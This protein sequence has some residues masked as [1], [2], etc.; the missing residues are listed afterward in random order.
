[1][2]SLNSTGVRSIAHNLPPASYA[3][4]GRR[5]YLDV[6]WKSLHGMP[7]C[8]RRVALY[9]MGG[10]GKSQILQKYANDHVNPAAKPQQYAIVIYI[11]AHSAHSVFSAV[12]SFM[13]LHATNEALLNSLSEND[14]NVFHSWLLQRQNWLLILDNVQDYNHILDAIPHGSSGHILCSTRHK[15]IAQQF[16]NGY[17]SQ[18]LEVREMGATDSTDLVLSLVGSSR[19]AED[20]DPVLATRVASFA[21]GIPLVIEQVV[22]N[23]LLG[24]RTLLST[25]QAV[26]G[27]AELLRQKNIS[28]LHPENLALGGVVMQAFETLQHVSDKAEA[29]FS[30]LAYMEPSSIPLSML[31]EGSKQL[32]DYLE[33][34]HTYDRGSIEETSEGRR[35]R[36]DK[37][38]T[39][40][41]R[42]SLWEEVGPFR[43]RTW[44]QAARSRS[45]RKA[46]AQAAL[47][48]DDI[49]LTKSLRRECGPAS[50]LGRLFEN[51]IT[52]DD[53]IAV[54]CDAAIV[55]KTGSGTLWIHDLVSEVAKA[56][57]ADRSVTSSQMTALT[58]ATTVYLA[59]PVP[60][61]NALSKK[62]TACEQYLPHAIACHQNLK[63][64]GIL[65]DCSIGPELSHII[66]SILNDCTPRE[67]DKDGRRLSTEVRNERAARIIKYYTDAYGGYLAGWE[68]LKNNYG[69]DD[70][71][72]YLSAYADREREDN[73]MYCHYR[74]YGG[75]ERFGRSAPWRAIQ[76]AVKLSYQIKQ[77]LHQKPKQDPVILEKVLSLSRHAVGFHKQA[78]GTNDYDTV[79]YKDILCRQLGEL[80][81][82]W[83]D[84]YDFC[85]ESIQDMVGWPIKR[86]VKVD[87]LRL[88][89]G[90]CIG[91]GL[92]LDRF[93]SGA[94]FVGLA[95]R[96]CVEISKIHRN[97]GDSI[98]TQRCAE[99]AVTWCQLWLQW[100]QYTRGAE[101]Y[102]CGQVMMLLGEA[103]ELAGGNGQALKWY[104][105]A[106]DCRTNV[107][108]L[109]SSEFRCHDQGV[110]DAI[111]LFTDAVSR[112]DGTWET[113]DVDDELKELLHIAEAKIEDWRAHK[114]EEARQ[115]KERV[116]ASWEMPV[117]WEAILKLP[118]T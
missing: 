30:I 74:Y 25:L 60:E 2:A 114:D 33:R 117:D 32:R 46:Q 47:P 39:S 27:N 23:A 42:S 107:E 102:V 95:G 76:T 118:E 82:R 15:T 43:L 53:A 4:V 24:E 94:V 63:S 98:E 87:I 103:Q 49:E 78:F 34:Q 41:S 109:G 69:I 89:R 22:H 58:A 31:R 113:E 81:G 67:V 71:R 96:C 45:A 111:Q 18:P 65:N 21:K 86:S 36:R 8:Q 85:I 11:N 108:W 97:A 48:I 20:K 56:L 106:V 28:S 26:S 35:D 13:R 37:L 6:I 84:A 88:Q 57:I 80:A 3:F 55:R 70:K 29:L 104:A 112:L 110:E 99:E 75:C 1:M 51:Q 9:G 5:Q 50:A 83:H 105:K 101:S 77:Q 52:I 91:T 59:L 19:Y 16:S 92:P 72:I 10:I 79:V 12:H 100:V 62:G 44:S 40:S 66:A 61:G 90:K 64:V 73:F 17:G 68:R 115:K 14:Y 54:L 7:S 116:R 93:S 38:A